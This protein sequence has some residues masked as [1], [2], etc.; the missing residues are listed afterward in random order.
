MQLF[1]RTSHVVSL[2]DAGRAFG[3]ESR[4]VLAGLELAVAEACRAA[5]RGSALRI[6]YT[7][8]LPIELLVT[9]LDGLHRLDVETQPRVEHLVALEQIRRLERGELD[10]GIFSSATGTDPRDLMLAVATGQGIALLPLPPARPRTRVRSSCSGR[11]IHRSSC[12]TP[13]SRGARAR[14]PSCGSS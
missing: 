4:R 2:T 3:E 1:D 6:G 14:Q 5:G 13:S 11:S 9:F 10:I 12:R 7:P 8:Y